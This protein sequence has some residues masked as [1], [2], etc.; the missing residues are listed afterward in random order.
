MSYQLTKIA[1]PN[2]L[3]RP[4]LEETSQA[5]SGKEQAA[6]DEE[7]SLAQAEVSKEMAR[8]G[9]TDDITPR[10]KFLSARAD[11]LMPSQEQGLAEKNP[12][13]GLVVQQHLYDTTQDEQ[14]LNFEVFE[15]Y[16]A[17]LIEKSG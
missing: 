8:L 5:V 3:K 13:T 10:S 16:L 2:Q 6:S 7:S 14:V 4:M 9:R 17:L 1:L 15:N 12:V 11:F